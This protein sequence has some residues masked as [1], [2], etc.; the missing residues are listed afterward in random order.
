M[1]TESGFRPIGEALR[2]TSEQNSKPT[3]CDKTKAKA[4]TLTLLGAYRSSDVDDP[5]V[6]VSNCIAILT[7][8]SEE[9]AAAVCHPRTGI[10]RRLKWPPTVAELVEACDREAGEIANRERRALLNRHRVLLDTPFGLKPEAEGL[11]LLQGPDAQ[12]RLT[13]EEREALA[14]RVQREVHAAAAA[15]RKKDTPPR[16]DVPPPELSDPDSQKLWYEYR[17]EVLRKRY[18]AEPTPVLSEAARATNAGRPWGAPDITYGPA[19]R[20]PPEGEGICG[21]DQPKAKAG[22]GVAA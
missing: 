19:P 16:D 2:P 20:Q 17:L 5:Q 3:L 21:T 7:G 9:V 10:Q 12:R 8:Y 11:A 18:A 14:E 13:P 6:F 4:F 1:S 15:Q 22:Q